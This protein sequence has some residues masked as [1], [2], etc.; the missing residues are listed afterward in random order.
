MFV[1]EDEGP[2]IDPSYRQRIFE[3]FFRVPSDQEGTGLGL[4]LARQLIELHGGR[5]W[6]EERQP[7]GSRFFF[8]L[9]LQA[10]GSA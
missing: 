1:V 2:G 8:S 4:A 9:P 7:S 6:V 5:I 3:Q 10:T